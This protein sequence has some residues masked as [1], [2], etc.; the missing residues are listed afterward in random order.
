MCLHNYCREP[1]LWVRPHKV[2][3]ISP[4]EFALKLV[5]A[6]FREFNA[7]PKGLTDQEI[8]EA[9][10]MT[11]KALVDGGG[12]RYAFRRGLRHSFG[13]VSELMLTSTEQ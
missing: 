12:A 4:G 1:S 13:G 2:C 6:D 3:G 5:V 9:F 10:K 11:L 8:N 7:T